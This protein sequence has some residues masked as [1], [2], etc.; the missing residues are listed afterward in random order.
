MKN[1]DFIL[2]KWLYRSFI[3]DPDPATEPQIF[4]QG[5]IDFKEE[6][7]GIL[8]AEFDFGK[9]GKMS[10]KG[11]ITFGE[12]HLLR[13]QGIGIKGTP[14]QEWLYDYR[15]YLNKDWVHGIDQRKSIVGSVIRSKDYDNGDSKAGKVASFI[16][17]K[18]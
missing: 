1:P 2:G 13:F 11:S 18:L 16:A 14:A 6:E 5:I 7:F 8:V 9:W 10:V 3:D 15:G 12:P 17:V 4:G